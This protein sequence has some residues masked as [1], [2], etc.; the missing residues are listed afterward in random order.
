MKKNGADRELTV[1]VKKK[2]IEH[3]NFVLYIYIPYYIQLKTI[4][5]GSKMKN[6]GAIFFKFYY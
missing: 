1:R 4:T 6:P 5:S 3:P 2:G